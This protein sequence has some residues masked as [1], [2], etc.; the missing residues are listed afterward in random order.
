MVV[1]NKKSK[2]RSL[3][4]AS[5]NELKSYQK[6]EKFVHLSQACEKTWVAFTLLLELK[7]GEEIVHTR[8]IQPTA[9]RLGFTA[10]LDKCILLHW[11]HYEGCAGASLED[12]IFRIEEAHRIIKREVRSLR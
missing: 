3:L 8:H 4:I 1:K 10:L 5:K 11:Y 9:R 2:I 6:N 12:I 7:S